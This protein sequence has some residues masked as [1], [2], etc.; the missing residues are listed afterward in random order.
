MIASNGT[1]G[2]TFLRKE[3]R[4]ARPLEGAPPS[5]TLGVIFPYYKLAHEEMICSRAVSTSAIVAGP[6]I[7]AVEGTLKSSSDGTRTF[8]FAM[9]IDMI[10]SA[11]DCWK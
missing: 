11:P 9:A 8:F 2:A 6:T 3:V 1:A 4:E 5:M 10:G 7:F